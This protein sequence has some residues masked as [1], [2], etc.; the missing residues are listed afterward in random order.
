[1][2]PPL[3]TSRTAQLNDSI[4]VYFYFGEPSHLSRKVDTYRHAFRSHFLELPC[5]RSFAT[6]RVHK[7][8][9]VLSLRPLFRVAATAT[10]VDATHVARYVT[11]VASP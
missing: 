9:T 7:E 3:L 4:F 10:D 11:L 6:G 2:R 1:M 8:N 5:I